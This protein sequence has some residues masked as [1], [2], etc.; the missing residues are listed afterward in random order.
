MASCS[1]RFVLRP[2]RPA[3]ERRGLLSDRC[4]LLPRIYSST[5][6]AILKSTWPP[7]LRVAW[8]PI[9]DSLTLPGTGPQPG[10]LSDAGCVACRFGAKVFDACLAGFDFC[11]LIGFRLR[12]V[13][14]PNYGRK[15]IPP[16]SRIKY[17]PCT[18][19]FGLGKRSLAGRWRVP[20]L[21]YSSQDLSAG[22]DHN[23]S[24]T[25]FRCGFDQ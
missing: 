16:H 2:L 20:S 11:L 25:R 14:F 8:S 1:K 7:S 22:R 3:N 17:I 10:D 21:S 24:S 5:N 23:A 9:L 12:A 13:I 18:S 6:G 15:M 19:R 4:T